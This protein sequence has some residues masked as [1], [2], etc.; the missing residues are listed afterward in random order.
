MALIENNNVF[1]N[2]C[3][4]FPCEWMKMIAVVVSTIEKY[5][6]QHYVVYNYSIGNTILL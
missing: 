4:A 1:D 3:Y 2:N 5:F 6:K